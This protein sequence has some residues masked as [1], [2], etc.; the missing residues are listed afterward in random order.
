MGTIYF[1]VCLVK[2]LTYVK[3]SCE[4]FSNMIIYTKCLVMIKLHNFNC[5]TDSPVELAF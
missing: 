5:K 4:V 3:Y 1:A 2:K